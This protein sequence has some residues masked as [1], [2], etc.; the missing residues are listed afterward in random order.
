MFLK[1]SPFI[2]HRS[3]YLSLPSL[4]Y[5]CVSSC[6]ASTRSFYSYLGA[7]PFCLWAA[8]IV[9]LCDALYQL[10]LLHLYLPCLRMESQGR[11]GGHELC[12]QGS[13]WA[14][15][16]LFSPQ[17]NINDAC[18]YQKYS[19]LHNDMSVV[20]IETESPSWPKSRFQILYTFQQWHYYVAVRKEPRN[21]SRI[22]SAKAEPLGSPALQRTIGAE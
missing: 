3:S 17:G 7:Y 4:K 12:Y 11:D 2:A 16:V 19:T 15:A 18:E 21:I 1:Q 22:T 5:Q 10:Q 6:P 20:K 9:K 13:M 14:N 8:F